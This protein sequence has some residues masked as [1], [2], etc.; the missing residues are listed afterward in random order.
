MESK[1]EILLELKNEVLNCRKCDLSNTRT[2]AVFGEGNFNTKVMFVGEAPG[3]DEDAKGLP[4]V[5]AAG[6]LLT[7]LIESIGLKREDVFIGNVLKCRPPQNRS[8]LKSE[9]DTC[10]PYLF[11]QIS[12]IKPKIICTLGNFALKLLLEDA[13]LTISPCHGKIYK[14]NEIF[15]LPMYH[16]AS[17][18]HKQDAKLKEIMFSDFKRLKLFLAKYSI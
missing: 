18:L 2:Q 8:P 1:E 4:F 3:K 13:S 14:K 9:I 11:A 12:L 15:F 6:K 16:P 5:G 7:E 17:S 10:S